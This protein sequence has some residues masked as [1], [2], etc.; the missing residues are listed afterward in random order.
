MILLIIWL[1]LLRCIWGRIC[2]THNPAIVN[3]WIT[4]GACQRSSYYITK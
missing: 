1:M 3:V 2:L 4:D